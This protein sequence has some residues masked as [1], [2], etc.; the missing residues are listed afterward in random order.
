M[1]H[2]RLTID[3][4]YSEVTR[5]RVTADSEKDLLREGARGAQDG[6]GSTQGRLVG[7]KISQPY[8]A[9]GTVIFTLKAF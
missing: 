6:P 8:R 1:F 5:G 7:I 4:L 9:V 2:S 3:K